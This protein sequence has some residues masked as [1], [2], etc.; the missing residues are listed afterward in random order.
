MIEQIVASKTDE[1]EDFTR[2]KLLNFLAYHGMQKIT[3][4]DNSGKKSTIKIASDGSY[5]IQITKNETM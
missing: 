5:K 2:G 4:Q 3:A 1:W